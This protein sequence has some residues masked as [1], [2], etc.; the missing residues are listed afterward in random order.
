MVGTDNQT[1]RHQIEDGAQESKMKVLQINTV[2]GKGSTGRITRDLR[3]CLKNGGTGKITYGVGPALNASTEDSIMI[4]TKL[5][6][7]VHNALSRFTDGAGGYS[8]L[9]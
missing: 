7:Y 3:S 4:D 5:K 1:G 2:C 9:R 6:Y 8:F